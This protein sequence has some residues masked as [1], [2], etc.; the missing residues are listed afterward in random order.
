M[1]RC[2]WN[3][4]SGD[5]LV[6]Q[7]KPAVT[8]EA[9]KT[10]SEPLDATAPQ[11]EPIHGEPPPFPMGN[12]PPEDAAPPSVET[13]LVTM[14]TM[15]N[16]QYVAGGGALIRQVRNPADVWAGAS[17]YQLR[18][19][20]N[21]KIDGTADLAAMWQASWD[22]QNLYLRIGVEDDRPGVSD[23][24]V[25]WEDDAVELYLDADGSMSQQY[26]QR[27]DFH[28]I[29]NLKAGNIVLGKNSPKID[30]VPLRHTVTRSGNGYVLDV[31]LPWAG[32]G[33]SPRAGQRMGLDI[34]VDDDDDGGDRDG[35][36]AWKAKQDD[37]W[38]NPAL[39]GGVIL[40]E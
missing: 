37:A 24:T 2:W 15:P 38:Q 18:N 21:G 4:C 3:G 8:L 11:Y 40:G 6:R 25:P 1:N 33:I 28:F 29:V 16:E 5:T 17:A 9:M 23:S 10:Q 39:F 13:T 30:R 7:A 26:D 12:I 31:T 20:L 22:Q 34:H 27:N 19:V 35:K 36:L 32:L 14:R